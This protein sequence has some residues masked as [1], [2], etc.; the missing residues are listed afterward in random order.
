VPT[1]L[2][3]TQRDAAVEYTRLAGVCEVLFGAAGQLVVDVDDP[4]S[5]IAIATVSRRLGRHAAAWA[6]LIPESVLLADVRG[7]VPPPDGIE[8]SLGAVIDALRDLRS[9]LSSLLDRLSAVADGAGRH[10]ASAVLA[11]LDEA[12]AHLG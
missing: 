11:D 8:P 6:D 2:F 1:E 9:R 7:A 4:P 10:L 5:K 12:L 3:F